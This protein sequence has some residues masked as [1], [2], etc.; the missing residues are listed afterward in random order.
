MRLLLTFFLACSLLGAVDLEWFAGMEIGS[1]VS[2]NHE[3]D[4]CSTADESNTRVRTGN[5]SLG[6]PGSGNCFV[7][8]MADTNEVWLRWYVN[9][10]VFPPAANESA[11]RLRLDDTT[12]IATLTSNTDGSIDIDGVGDGG[13]SAMAADT[14][15]LYE[16]HYL[17]GSGADGVHQLWIAGVLE[18]DISNSADQSDVDGFHIEDYSDNT[19]YDDVAISSTARI[20]AGEVIALR[21]NADASSPDTFV[22]QSAGSTTWSVVDDDPF[23]TTTYAIAPTSGGPPVG[24]EWELTTETIGTINGAVLV[25]EALDGGGGGGSETVRPNSTNDIVGYTTCTSGGELSDDPDSPDGNWCNGVG[26]DVD[27][28]VDV[29]LATP[30]ASPDSATNAQEMRACLRSTGQSSDPTCTIDVLEGNT[31]RVASI[32]SSTISQTV[33]TAVSAANWTFDPGVWDTDDGSTVAFGVDCA[34]GGGN[35]ANRAS[36]ELGAIEWNVAT[37]SSTTH[38]LIVNDVNNSALLLGPDLGLTTVSDMYRLK[39]TGASAP[40]SQ[41]D[42]DIYR[43]GVEQ[44]VNGNPRAQVFDAALMIDHVPGAPAGKRRVLMNL[45]AALAPVFHGSNFAGITR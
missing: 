12:T 25:V 28:E 43:I 31:V 40:V 19:W 8:A 15:V 45:I 16:W 13:D 4:S 27:T 10:D 24:Q 36:G 2:S 11:V 20:F 6:I 41:A 44:S 1:S 22:T 37:A 21:P 17:A 38:K 9:V 33:C 7:T 18:I 23:T 32:F 26:T 35:P 14:W 29:E 42:V 34:P 39:A 3:W 5:W 30:T